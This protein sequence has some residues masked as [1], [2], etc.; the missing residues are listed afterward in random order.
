MS[1]STRARHESALASLRRRLA[2][3][4]VVAALATCLAGGALL[5]SRLAAATVGAWL[6]VAAAVLAV[7]LGWATG[8]LDRNRRAG[9]TLL[10]RLGTGNFVTL[11]RG[12]LLAW[13]A[14]FVVVDWTDTAALLW[15][16]TALYGTAAALDA[17]DGALARGNDRVTGF[18]TSLDL[19]YDALGVLVACSVGVVAGLLPLWYL[20]IGL[21]RYAF[22]LAR[23]LRRRRGVPVYDLP[24]RVSRRPLAGL[25]MAFLAA[26]LSPVPDPSVR[27]A[28]ATVFGGALLLG[29]GRDWLYVSGRVGGD[30][31]SPTEHVVD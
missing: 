15:V 25:Q 22:G 27:T 24:P 10:A 16:P 21:A 6:F 31:K 5:A 8:Q 28:G 13:V 26:A 4:A 23:Y 20:S 2:A 12:V 29:F 30:T 14:A 3:F 17:A 1:G 11:G 7:E 18:G 19:E 9:E